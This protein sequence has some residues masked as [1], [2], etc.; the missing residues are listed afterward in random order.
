MKKLQNLTE[1]QKLT[2]LVSPLPLVA[3]VASVALLSFYIDLMSALFIVVSLLLIGAIS[4]GVVV[5][6][7]KD[8]ELARVVRGY[9]ALNAENADSARAIHELRETNRTLTE[10]LER[11]TLNENGLLNLVR[12]VTTSSVFHNVGGAIY[13]PLRLAELEKETD[14]VQVLRALVIADGELT[15]DRLAWYAEAFHNGEGVGLNDEIMLDE[16]LERAQ[17]AIDGGDLVERE[18]SYT[19]SATDALMLG[20]LHRAYTIR[21]EYGTATVYPLA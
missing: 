19:Y 8:Y 10:A 3:L 2:A 9:R 6:V 15:N 12:V 1:P 14:T 11:A 17:Y 21:N 13:E 5:A 4:S 16:L 18:P 7:V 20:T